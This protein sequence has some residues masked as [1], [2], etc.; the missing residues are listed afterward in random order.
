[1]LFVPFVVMMH[2]VRKHEDVPTLDSPQSKTKAVF[3]TLLLLI[4]LSL[5]ASLHG[6]TMWTDEAADQQWN[7]EKGDHFLFVSEDTLGCTGCTHS[8]LRLMLM[9]NHHRSLAIDRTPMDW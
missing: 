3:A 6:Q 1:M 4:P 5:M 2:Y 9:E 8:T 7:L